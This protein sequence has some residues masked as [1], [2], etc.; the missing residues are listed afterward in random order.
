MKQHDQ[1]VCQATVAVVGVGMITVDWK[2]KRDTLVEASGCEHLESTKITDLH[3]G[4]SEQ[5]MSWGRKSIIK[6]CRI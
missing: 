2:R 3:Y 4:I 6:L 1:N 5:R